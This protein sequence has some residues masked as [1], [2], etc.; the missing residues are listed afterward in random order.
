MFDSDVIKDEYRS[1]WAKLI[2]NAAT[3]FKHAQ[4]DP[5]VEL[6]FNPKTNWGLLM[7]G[8]QGLQKMGEPAGLEESAIVGWFMVHRP[9]WFRKTGGGNFIPVDAL[10]HLRTVDKNEFFQ[11]YELIWR[12]R[13][14]S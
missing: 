10:D 3:F 7:A 14:A 9:N 6:E 5:D 11:A 8:V 4:R 1:D 12:Q 13:T 2:K